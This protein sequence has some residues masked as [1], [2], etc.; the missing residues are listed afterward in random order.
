M[1]TKL[2]TPNIG[3]KFELDYKFRDESTVVTEIVVVDV[4]DTH[5]LYKIPSMSVK[6]IFPMTLKLWRENKDELRK[7]L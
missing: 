6:K 3:D 4:T 1:S 2:E 7:K 5:V